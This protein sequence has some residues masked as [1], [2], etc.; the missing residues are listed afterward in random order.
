MV[1]TRAGRKRKYDNL[2]RTELEKCTKEEL[3]DKIFEIRDSAWPPPKK[4]KKAKSRFDNLGGFYRHMAFKVAYLGEAFSG[5]QIQENCSNTISEHI[6]RALTKCKLVEDIKDANFAVCG[7]TDKGVSSFGNVFS[8]LVKTRVFGGIGFLAPANCEQDKAD[9]VNTSN[10]ATKLNGLNCVVSRGPLPGVD[11]LNGKEVEVEG[12][13]PSSE[14]A[15]IR[16]PKNAVREDTELPE[17]EKTVNEI[18]HVKI[19]NHHLPS[20]I[21]VLACAPVALDFTPR[22]RCVSRSYRYFFFR[23][24]MNLE[25]VREAAAFIE[26]P[27]DFRNFAKIDVVSVMTWE[28]T[29]YESRVVEVEHS[30]AGEEQLCFYEIKGDGFLWHMVRNICAILFLVG[31]GKEEPDIVSRMLD[32]KTYPCKPLYNMVDSSPLVLWDCDFRKET[33]EFP[34]AR[35]QVTE[36]LHQLMRASRIRSAILKGFYDSTKPARAPIRREEPYN[37]LFSGICD[38]SVERKIEKLTGNRR[39]K[40]LH[41]RKRFDYYLENK[42]TMVDLVKDGF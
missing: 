32:I 8:V 20:N 33:L 35:L 41:K 21:R 11:I 28:R 16:S 19:L 4:K 9:A 30:S 1:R 18:D 15:K 38:E 25:R 7:R 10:E 26:G 36:K 34:A 37:R 2:S 23:G 22:H 3:I 5:F 31:L 6:F 14:P 40:Y 24:R 12:L 42:K 29:V 27:H 17:E 39:K 13:K